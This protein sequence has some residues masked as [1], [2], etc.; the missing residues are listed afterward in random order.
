MYVML[1]WKAGDRAEEMEMFLGQASPR[2]S[3][4]TSAWSVVK[5]GRGRAP[6]LPK[7]P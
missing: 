7:A 2:D 6:K 3:V 4:G 5:R 1:T